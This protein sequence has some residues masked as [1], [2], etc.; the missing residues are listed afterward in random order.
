MKEPTQ[1]VV[2]DE[3]GNKI[4]QGAQREAKEE[5]VDMVGAAFEVTNIRARHELQEVVA[6]CTM[7][8][9]RSWRTPCSTRPAQP[10]T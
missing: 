5:K 3:E 6:I 4:P 9:W 1:P 8:A 10:G 7:L 2:L